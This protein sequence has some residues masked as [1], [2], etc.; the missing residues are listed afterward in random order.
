[1]A[2]KDILVALTSYPEPTPDSAVADAISFAAALD[3]RIS[4]VCCEVR[5]QVPSSPMGTAFLNVPGMVGAE[6]KKSAANAEHLMSTFQRLAEKQNVF[7]ERILEKC[8]TSEVPDILVDYA[9]L[10]DLTIIPRAKNDTFGQWY[11]ESIIFGSGR[12]TIVLP[13]PQSS[14]RTASLDT[15][16]VGW[17]FSRAASRA[18]ADAMP[19]LTRAKHV[20]ILT[21]SDEKKIDSKRSGAEVAKY[22]ARHGVHVDLDMVRADG[23]SIGQVFEAHLALRNADL[24][25]MGAF[26]HSRL[27]EFVLGGAT[28]SMLAHPPPVPLFLTH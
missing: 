27:R 24:L 5:I 4:A 20:F 25:V 28:R 23:R 7:Q 14:P 26:G 19:I 18:V 8:F 9:K 1:M 10:R 22:L 11:A 12:P 16:V 6:H 13:D 15:V 21:V 17:D 2:F 3:A